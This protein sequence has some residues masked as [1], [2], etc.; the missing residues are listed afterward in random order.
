MRSRRPRFAVLGCG[1]GGQAL[2]ADIALKEF[3]VNIGTL[4][5]F[6]ERLQPICRQGG[7]SVSGPLGERF[8]APD[9][10][11]SNVADLVRDVDVVFIAAPAY[12]NELLTKAI[13]PHLIDGQYVVF[14]SHF[15]ALGFGALLRQ[16]GITTP[17]I[18][19]ECLSLPYAARLTGPASVKIYSVRKSLPVAALPAGRTEDFLGTV[20]V[21]FPQMTAVESVLFTSLNNVGPAMHAPLLLLN[22]A[23]VEN[24]AGKGW[25]LYAE[26]FTGAV[27]RVALQVERERS[28]LAGFLRVENYSLTSSLRHLVRGETVTGE[29]LSQAV[30]ASPI[31]TNPEVDNPESLKD[32]F[33]TES[34]PFGLVP[35]ASL[36]DMYS[37]PV[38]VIKSLIHLA[39]TINEVDYFKEG[40]TVEKLGLSG[41]GPA[42]LRERVR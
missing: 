7:I 18:P 31:F 21:V 22:A 9:L 13:A 41:L 28:A 42:E 11:T 40:L 23:R 2:A 32:R 1:N 33:I 30:R 8:A 39:S 15:G 29:S 16:M 36:A 19:V 17:A 3:S 25:N 14:L 20:S 24:T 38:P 12:R 27:G 34:V 35:W 10:V 26:G 37:I 4:P 6:A 5:E